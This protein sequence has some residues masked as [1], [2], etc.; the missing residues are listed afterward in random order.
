[1]LS[2]YEIQGLIDAGELD[3]G[4]WL[5]NEALNQSPDDWRLLCVSASAYIKMEKF[6]FAMAMLRRA[7]TMC[8]NNSEL[9]N[10]IAMC[11][12]G[13]MRLDEAEAML[14]RSLK[15]NPKN[16]NAMNN[17]A[18]VY[19]NKCEPGLAIEWGE[20]S[21][22]I[23]GD[24]PALMETLGYAHLM[25]RQWQKGWK[26]FEGGLHGKIRRP[27][28]YQG[29]GYWDG[30]PVETL[31]VR[32]EQGVGDE[33]S[34]ASVI[35][36]ALKVA[37]RVVVECDSRLHSLFQRSFP[38][39]EFHGTRFKKEALPWVPDYQIDAHVLSGSLCQYFRN[40]DSDF[41]GKPYLKAD[42]ERK[43]QWKALLASLGPR[44]KIGIAWTGGSHGTHRGRRSTS[45][46]AWLP[47]LRQDADFVSLEYRDPSA[48]IDALRETHGVTV[49]HWP[50]A[51]EKTGS[52]DLEDT[53]ALIDELDLVISVQTAAVHIAGALG[54]PCW[55]MVPRRPHWR[56]GMEGD[57]MPWY[58]SVKL[59]RQKQDWA[60]VV[61]RIAADLNA[62]NL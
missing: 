1:M 40:N 35:P 10:N 15:L 32:G 20:K 41:D 37:E 36:D 59:Y 24:D 29:E 56:Y 14:K 7:E 2:L 54:K 39:I 18:L 8:P 17:L 51:V 11:E 47:I 23:K 12:L 57:R 30:S 22:A 34:F 25:L 49:R 3:Q 53:A 45:L 62:R 16:A 9:L 31:V 21:R 33:I 55:V 19:V 44:P 6:G 52:A 61:N 48:E 46:E 4:T 58:D 13:C 26:G 28:S 38:D 50:R 27:R 43:V 5:A 42:P 60:G